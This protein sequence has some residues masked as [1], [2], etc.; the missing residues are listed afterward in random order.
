MNSR[1][2]NELIRVV[3]GLLMIVA[4]MALFMSKTSVSSD[5]LEYGGGWNW[6]KILLVLLPLAAGIVLLAVKPHLK[7]SGIVA[8]LG[9]VLVVAVILVNTT[10]IIEKDIA[11][12]EWVIYGVLI[13]GGMLV[14]VLSLFIRRK[15]K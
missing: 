10:I 3:A 7:V 2:R 14:S 11:S 5:F 4:G 12:Y 8:A 1:A 13:F 9:A 6:W 15:K